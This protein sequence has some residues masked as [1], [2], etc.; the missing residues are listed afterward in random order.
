MQPR[1]SI[2]IPVMN[3]MPYIMEAVASALS[4]SLKEIEVVISDNASDDGTSEYLQS[5]SDSRLIVIRQPK[6]VSASENWNIVTCAAKGDYVKLLCADDTISRDCLSNQLDAAQ[7][8]DVVLVSSRRK[9][10]NDSGKTVIKKH[11]LFFLHGKLDGKKAVK[12]SIATGTNQ[13]GEPASVLFERSVLF[14]CLPWDSTHPATVDLDMYSRVLLHGKFVGLKT[15]DATF[16][17]TNNSWSQTIGDKHSKQFNEWLLNYYS[18]KGSEISKF[19]IVTGLVASKLNMRLRGV[20]IA[21][22]KRMK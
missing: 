4:G 17:I 2:V 18:T 15:I 8:P 10:V 13:F 22:S 19:W 14:S 21:T 3:G 20:V 16:R 11:G 1:V 6:R 9:I 5:L 12:R 7:Q